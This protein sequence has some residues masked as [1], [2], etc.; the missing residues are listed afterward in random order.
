MRNRPREAVHRDRPG[1]VDRTIRTWCSWRWRRRA[2]PSRG[3][4]AVGDYCCCC[5]CLR[6]VWWKTRRTKKDAED[7]SRREN[8]ERERRDRV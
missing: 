2:I 6:M 4:L 7:A 8:G 5:C 1:L 3:A